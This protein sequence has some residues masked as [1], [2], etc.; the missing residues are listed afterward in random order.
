MIKINKILQY[1]YIFLCSAWVI[2]GIIAFT[3]FDDYHQTLTNIFIGILIAFIILSIGLF[4][5]HVSNNVKGLIIEKLFLISSILNL[6]IITYGLYVIIIGG[7]YGLVLYSLMFLLAATASF[8]I[9]FGLAIISKVNSKVLLW[10][11]FILIASVI[12]F[13][14]SKVLNRPTPNLDYIEIN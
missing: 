9:I 3:K 7:D 2:Y 8:S 14:I 12:T 13:Y 4:H 11:L 5:K 1:V 10:I 6:I